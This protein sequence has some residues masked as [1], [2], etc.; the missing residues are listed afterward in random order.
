MLQQSSLVK[1]PHPLFTFDQGKLNS[2]M[3][4][5]EVSPRKL[6]DYYLTKKRTNPSFSISIK[7]QLRVGV[8]EPHAFKSQFLVSVKTKHSSGNQAWDSLQDCVQFFP[9]LS[10]WHSNVTALQNWMFNSKSKHQKANIFLLLPN[11]K[12]AKNV[13]NFLLERTKLLENW[14]CVN[15]IETSTTVIICDLTICDL[16]QEFSNATAGLSPHTRNHHSILASSLVSRKALADCGKIGQTGTEIAEKLLN[17]APHKVRSWLLGNQQSSSLYSKW[18]R[19]ACTLAMLGKALLA[20]TEN[21]LLV[22]ATHGLLEDVWS[23]E[24]P[25]LPVLAVPVQENVFN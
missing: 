14:A 20:E 5:A 13:T 16:N 4:S 7:P 17:S 25:N 22:H 10:S 3:Q 18:K 6:T 9:S 1:P 21:P 24:A 8:K 23:R 11:T 19:D 12:N 2:L 15:N